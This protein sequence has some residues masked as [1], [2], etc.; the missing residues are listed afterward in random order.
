MEYKHFKILFMLNSTN[1]S[2]IWEMELYVCLWPWIMFAQLIF[3]SSFWS[4]NICDFD[5]VDFLLCWKFGEM[6]V[7]DDNVICGFCYVIER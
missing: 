7:Y 4:T 1:S 5:C 2:T 3:G 6:N